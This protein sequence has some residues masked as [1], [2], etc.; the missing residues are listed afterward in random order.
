MLVQRLTNL[1]W[2]IIHAVHTHLEVVLSLGVNFIVKSL[3]SA[4]S[5]AFTVLDKNKA[6]SDFLNDDVES[7]I[8]DPLKLVQ[9]FPKPR[10]FLIVCLGDLGE[11]LFWQ[12][13]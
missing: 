11:S 3:R 9:V 6:M 8:N 5:D 7:F 1:R 4:L 12:L 10:E 2:L 13:A